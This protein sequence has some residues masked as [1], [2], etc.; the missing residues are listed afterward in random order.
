MRNPWGYEEDILTFILIYD[1]V[2]AYPETQ[3]NTIYCCCHDVF[4]IIS[5]ICS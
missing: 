1:T 4:N 2:K 5:Y 3:K